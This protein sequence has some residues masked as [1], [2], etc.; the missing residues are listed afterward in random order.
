MSLS[1][2]KLY[3]LLPAFYRL[4][5]AEQGHVLRD[6]LAVFAEQMDILA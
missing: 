6:L 5:D 2:Q 4:R 3:D 1:G